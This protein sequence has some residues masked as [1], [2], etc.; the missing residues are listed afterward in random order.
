MTAT[1]AGNRVINLKDAITEAMT[2]EMD[3]DDRVFIL[4]EDITDPFGGIFQVTL[5]ISTK[6]GDERALETPISESAILGCATGAAL[7]GL[8]PIAEIML[9]DFLGVCMDQLYNQAAKM[10]FMSGGQVSVPMV[11]R[12]ESGVG[13]GFGAQHSQSL[14]AWLCHV[15]GLKVVFPSTA[16][17]AKGLMTAAIRDNNPV[18]FI[19]NLN[20]YWTRSECPVGEHIVPLG[21]AAVR[22][23]GS[24]CTMVAWGRVTI[25][26]EE[27]AAK[28]AEEG[29]DVEFI[30]PRTLVPLDLE[31]ILK[32]VRKTGRLV[33]I[34]EAVERGGF[35]GEIAALVQAQVWDS[36]KG[37][38]IRVA[39]SNSPVPYS[40]P[41]E[42]AMIPNVEDIVVAVRTA[43]GA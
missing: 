35:G 4:G 42:K 27:A 16:S 9:I 43:M 14:E 34:H 22:R 37:P 30:D 31:A 3:R 6:F 21:V 20:L 32:S 39:A 5:G 18:V 40:K 24:D 26:A 10:S 7:S 29:I 17:D 19:E 11:V 41:L 8:R 33:I 15:P 2:E 23:T 36:L 38:V 28:L 12:V 1:T 25:E 13:G